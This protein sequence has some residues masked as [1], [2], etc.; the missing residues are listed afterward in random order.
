MEQ[1]TQ[2]LT[3]S[4]DLYRVW[5]LDPYYRDHNEAWSSWDGT[6]ILSTPRVNQSADLSN[7]IEV[8]FWKKVLS[9]NALIV[10][11]RRDFIP[12]SVSYFYL[13]LISVDLQNSGVQ[14]E[15]VATISTVQSFTYRL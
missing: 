6:N 1:H 15:I 9:T 11:E 5:Y 14:S 4:P 13:C 8:I 7:K 3:S 12:M 2:A 10:R